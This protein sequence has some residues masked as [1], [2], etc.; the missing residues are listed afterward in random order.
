MRIVFCN[1][2]NK[3]CEKKQ[4]RKNSL[5]SRFSVACK[6]LTNSLAGFLGEIGGSL[7]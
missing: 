1:L 4:Y 2:T 5:C 6:Q 7:P 3:F